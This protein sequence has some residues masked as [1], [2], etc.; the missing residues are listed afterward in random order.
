MV[1]RSSAP[2]F[3]KSYLA[4]RRGSSLKVFFQ[5][6]SDF[7]GMEAI[8]GAFAAAATLRRLGLKMWIRFWQ[9]VL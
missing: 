8:V 9:L 1:T 5:R 2:N 4:S 3:V 7:A 6:E